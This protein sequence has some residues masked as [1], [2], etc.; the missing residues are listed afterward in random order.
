MSK[1]EIIKKA[2]DEGRTILTEIES[3]E[4]MKE[5][6]I[7]VVDTF[8]A[9]SSEEAIAQ[10]C[11]TGFPVG[12]KITSPDILHKSD[13]GGVK[14]NLKTNEEVTQAC[15]DILTSARRYDPKA[16]IHGI[17]V[18]KM[19]RPG[20]EVIIGMTKDPQFGPVL[21]FG[22]GGVMV[23]VIKDVSLRA[24][25]LNPR[26]AKEM[27]REIKGYKMLIGFRGQPPVA[28]SVLEDWLLK[29]SR[30]VEATPEI[31]EVD[32]NPVFAYSDGALAVDAR[33]ILESP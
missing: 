23:E 28:A 19:A 4:L 20:V 16:R 32:L 30:F 22:L 1:V 31:K 6:G 2:R 10:C 17:A 11:I 27:I 7:G 21:M 15:E 26:D 24:V 33:V 13:A 5:A 12:L 14:L 9:A 3:K 8:L 25:P 18:Q 29:L